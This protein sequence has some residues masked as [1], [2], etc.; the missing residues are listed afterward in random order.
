M[1][2]GT[3]IAH[4]IAVDRFLWF[5]YQHCAFCNFNV[6]QLDIALVRVSVQ[7]FLLIAMG[8][9]ASDPHDLVT[10]SP[11]AP[12]PATGINNQTLPCEILNGLFDL[13]RGF[14]NLI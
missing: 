7:L 1:R 9:F 13:I 3:S 10:T 4:L 14:I 12:S 5:F 11:L 6:F 8:K 2:F